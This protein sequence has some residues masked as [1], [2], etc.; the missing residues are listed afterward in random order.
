M[1]TATRD[2]F[3]AHVATGKFAAGFFA[4][5][6]NKDVQ[7]YRDN[8]EKAG[9]PLRIGGEVAQIWQDCVDQLEPKSDFTMIYE[10]TRKSMK[11]NG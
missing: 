8:A 6:L 11:P 10:V 9:T 1:N 7:L 4:E 3:P 5:L 2:K